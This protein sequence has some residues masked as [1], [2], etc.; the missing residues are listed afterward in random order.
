MRMPWNKADNLQLDLLDA[1]VVPEAPPALP[2]ATSSVASR[3]SMV[4]TSGLYE[5]ANN[6]RTEIPDAELD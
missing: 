1:P 5:D 2:T 6:P 3:P 4:P